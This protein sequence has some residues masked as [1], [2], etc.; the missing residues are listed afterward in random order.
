MAKSADVTRNRRYWDGIGADAH[1]PVARAHWE[2]AEPSWGLWGTP[3][4]RAG[5]IPAD[6]A[7]QR[8][9][10]LGCGTG[11][12]SAWLARA[13]ARVVGVDVSARQLETA[14]AL[15]DEFGLGF[16][17]V[18]ADAGRV[19]CRDGVFDFAI[20]EYGA[21]LWCDP[22]HWIPEAARLLAPGGRLVFVRPSPLFAM[23]LPERGEVGPELLRPLFGLRR[24]EWQRGATEFNLP[25]GEL[26]GLLRKTGFEVEELL[27]LAAPEGDP[28][29]RW[30]SDDSTVEPE[31]ARQWPTE[32]IWKVRRAG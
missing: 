5:V 17:L 29:T 18:Q 27:E 22:Q 31:W 7:G 2:A 6:I 15:R 11:Y 28:G 21:S 13:G 8:A 10:E 14:R 3:E 20:S 24:L 9:I 26:I 25:H 4:A 16:A 12:V 23:C 32:E 30:F 19:P 1:G